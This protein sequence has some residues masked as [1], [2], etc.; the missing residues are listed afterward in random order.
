MTKSAVD[1]KLALTVREALS[2]Q[3]L[4]QLLFLNFSVSPD[5]IMPCWLAALALSFAL[6]SCPCIRPAHG[7]STS[8]D[9]ILGPNGVPL[10]FKGCNW[11]GFNNGATMVRDLSRSVYIVLGT[12]GLLPFQINPLL[13][14][15]CTHHMILPLAVG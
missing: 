5:V 8:N 13:P 7:L 3:P 15:V 2:F 9:A 12:Q 6:F 1:R 11:F 14:F 10:T 4:S